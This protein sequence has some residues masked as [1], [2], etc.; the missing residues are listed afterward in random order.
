VPLASL[1]QEDFGAGIY[2]GRKAPQ[3]SLYD[4]VNGLIN[5]EGLIYRRGG[6][7]YYSA[8]DA[9]STPLWLNTA[10]MQA[11]AANRVL[12]TSTT[13]MY[14]LN[15][16]LA[17][18]V[19]STGFASGFTAGPGRPAN[20]GPYAVFANNT[21]NIVFYGGSVKATDYT[22]GTIA[23]TAGSASVTGTTTAFLANVDPG[24]IL[25][26]VSGVGVVKTVNSNTSITLVEPWNGSTGTP[27]S[28]TLS[29]NVVTSASVIA[30]GRMFVAAAGGGSPRLLL[31]T[32]N[33]VYFT[34]PGDPFS[35]DISA[36]FHE[37]PANA[38]IVGAEG[39]GDSALFFTTAGIWSISNLSFDAV[40][41]YGN[42]QHTV[43]QVNKD[44]ILWDDYG[45]ARS[46]EGLVIP[47]TDDVLVL[48]DDGFT[49]ITGRIR[50]LYRSYVKAGYQ[51]G[52]AAVHRGHYVLPILNGS[53][54]V[55]VLVCRLDRDA[56]WTTW[57]GGA[58]GVAY[59]PLV[60]GTTRQPK[61]LGLKAARV[62]DLSACFDPGAATDADGTT[63]D[64]V[65]VTRDMPTG[66]NQ[67]GFAAKVR[68]RYELE[69]GDV[70]TVTPAFSSDQDN[71]VYATLTE[72]G[73]Q[74]G[75]TGWAD[76]DGSKYQFAIVGKR[77]ERIRFR[78]TVAG[79]CS[80]FVLRS[81]ELLTRPSGKQ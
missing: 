46:A 6:S 14:A 69:S 60:S 67:P 27:G 22:S 9:A 76:S 18:V 57:A 19:V 52:Q 17:P 81:L 47:A 54:L 20:V 3:N 24:M 66:A 73:E 40:D 55:D 38:V 79:A 8:S 68:A 15:G 58:A 12:L 65:I 28:Y 49:A 59:A 10:Y 1:P 80:R 16:S 29:P 77:R 48:S 26:T 43:A 42:I 11:P 61:L 51:T 23:V 70:A 5:D 75:G 56:A 78:L 44:V 53:T 35:F 62:T 4:C 71:D 2:R 30:R 25:T 33:R 41:A 72:R 21:S 45:I 37:L 34:E 63:S 50:P 39:R 32:G 7:A 13:A 64:M 36:G 74:A 31:T